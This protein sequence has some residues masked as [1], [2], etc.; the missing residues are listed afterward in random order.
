MQKNDRLQR[1]SY[2]KEVEKHWLEIYPKESEVK[3]V[4]IDSYWSKVFEIKSND[5]R[6]LFPQLA[7]LIKSVLTLSHGNAGP[8][9]GFSLNKA[10]I[11]AH[12]TRLGEDILIA[13]RRIKHRILQVGGI[14]IFEITQPLLE[15]IKQSRS[16]YDEEMK[17]IAYKKS[18]KANKEKDV[19]KNKNYLI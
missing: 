9:Q 10:I 15:S 6:F 3:S 2:W 19:D 1:E 13:L 18:S 12:G 11:D 4:R 17:S 8:E 5:G 14:N 7:A 16:R